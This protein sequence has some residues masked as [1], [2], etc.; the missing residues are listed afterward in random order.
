MG[1]YMTEQRK[2]LISFLEKNPHEMYSA[3]EIYEALS[4][5]NI[6]L[7]A[8]YRNMNALEEL[9]FVTRRGKPDTKEAYYQYTA[10]EDCKNRIHL[11]CVKCGKSIHMDAEE[12]DDMV[13]GVLKKNGFSIDKSE[14]ILYGVCGKCRKK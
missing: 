3:R 11:T 7:S 13:C 5:G 4:D 14:T 9:G 6:S 10:N 1:K 12:A 8:V 2:R